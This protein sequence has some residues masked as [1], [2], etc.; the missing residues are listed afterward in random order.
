MVVARYLIELPRPPTSLYRTPYTVFAGYGSLFY[1]TR[2]TGRRRRAAPDQL[3]ETC[4]YGDCPDDIK[5]RYTQNTIADKILKYGSGGVFLGGLGIGTGAGAAA[6]EAGAAAAADV[7]RGTLLEGGGVPWPRP[8]VPEQGTSFIPGERPFKLPGSEIPVRVDNSSRLPVQPTPKV[9]E[10]NVFVNPAFDGSLVSVS[11]SDG[12]VIGDPVPVPDPVQPQYELPTGP[13]TRGDTFVLEHEA[14]GGEIDPSR[15]QYFPALSQPPVTT[16]FETVE[17]QTIGGSRPVEEYEETS[18]I[19]PG[20]EDA[21]L[22]STPDPSTYAVQ[23]IP[24]RTPSRFDITI[25]NPLYGDNVEVERI[26]QE[27]LDAWLNDE[28]ILGDE[29]LGTRQGRVLYGRETVVPGIALRSGRQLGA[30]V[31]LFAEL[32]TIHPEEIE[33]RS[34]SAVGTGDTVIDG[35][36]LLESN[37]SGNPTVPWDGRPLGDTDVVHVAPVEDPEAGFIDIPLDDP[38]PEMEIIDDDFE[39]PP[40]TGDIPVDVSQTVERLGANSLLFT[41]TTYTVTPK[42]FPD[43][44]PGTFVPLRPGLIIDYDYLPELD[45]FLLYLFRRRRRRRRLFRYR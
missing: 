37:F 23:R 27:G 5:D 33:L 45:P 26:F 41:S 8:A 35:T 11:S 13:F 30:R 22:T 16:P 14:A 44:S 19:N 39:R 34:F 42:V 2:V 40:G 21:A 10:D 9:T 38:F 31:G 4:R 17:L 28:I 1:D 6:G 43:H 25:E 20:Y 7:G 32:S 24:A 15:E 18:F 3:W 36:T 29:V 12:V